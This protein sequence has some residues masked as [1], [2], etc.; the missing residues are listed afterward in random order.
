MN[1]AK[2]E[3]CPACGFV[4]DANLRSSR[5]LR[6]FYKLI[7]RALEQWPEHHPFQ[8]GR[9]REYFR[10]WLLV[11]VGYA[12]KNLI[13]LPLGHFSEVARGDVLA[14]VIWAFEQ[15][16]QFDKHC[17]RCGKDQYTFRRVQGY[18]VLELKPKSISFETLSQREFNAIRDAVTE[19]I[20]NVIGVTAEQLLNEKAA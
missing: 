10:A 3:S 12:D 9:D 20:E 11:E 18:T 8:A 1:P 16:E 5:D 17:A 13:E 7:T 2:L 14:T 19:V 6:R 15:K 4:L